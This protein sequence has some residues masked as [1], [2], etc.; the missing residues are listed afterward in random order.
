MAP[1]GARRG[2]HQ[3]DA[4]NAPRRLGPP[5]GLPGR[6]GAA[7]RSE[8]RPIPLGEL[9]MVPGKVIIRAT[10]GALTRCG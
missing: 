1:P 2:G 4:Q 5:G 10:S 3:G 6:R 8:E 7:A 9:I